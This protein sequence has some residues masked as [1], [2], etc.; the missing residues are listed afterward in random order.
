MEPV[1]DLKL[2]RV[3]QEYA[4]GDLLAASPVAEG[5]AAGYRLRTSEGLF[6]V[7]KDA[8]ADQA[9][10]RLHRAVEQAL[11][12]KGVKQARLLAAPTG[13][14]ISAEG[15]VVYE[16]LPGSTARELNDAQFKN[17]ILYLAR[18]NDALT[19]IPLDQSTV[20]IEALTGWDNPRRK[21]GSLEYL[22]GPF[23]EDLQAM[24][25]SRNVRRTAER[26]LAVLS[27]LQKTQSDLRK[28]LVHS[29]VGPGNILFERDEVVAI[30]DFTPAY[31]SHL[32]ALCVSL[33]WH[34]VFP[35]AGD[36]PLHRVKK[37]VA[38]YESSHG[39]ADSEK[40]SFFGLFVKAVTFRL[41]A[42]LIVNQEGGGFTAKSIDYMSR[43][44]RGVLDARSE[45]EE[46]V[47]LR[48]D[49]I[50]P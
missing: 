40:Q 3:A 18:Y 14:L 26:A 38:L 6:F 11:T 24:P 16:W 48:G 30:I 35:K 19:T 23:L 31:E 36:L 47:S 34:C 46:E 22:L 7:K 43:C 32:Y 5:N 13:N 49:K 9:M 20:A 42:R 10:L 41:F 44:L 17:Y 50:Y 15:F 1:P 29:D 45:L 2:V 21:A 12:N 8:G 37:A 33:F 28:Q 4:L 25:L 27:D 39:L